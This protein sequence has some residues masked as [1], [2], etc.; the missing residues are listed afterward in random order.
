MDNSKFIIHILY[1]KEIHLRIGA[2]Q[3]L[4]LKRSYYAPR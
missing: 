4:H 1:M 3:E 2:L